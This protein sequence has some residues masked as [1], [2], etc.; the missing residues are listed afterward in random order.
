VISLMI[1]DM[2]EDRCAVYI[3]LHTVS[4]EPRIN[5]IDAAT[6]SQR[7]MI[8]HEAIFL[9]DDRRYT[10]TQS[11]QLG[12]A[13]GVCVS[14]GTRIAL[15]QHE[16]SSPS[17]ANRIARRFCK[18]QASR[19]RQLVVRPEVNMCS[20]RRLRAPWVARGYAAVA[21]ARFSLCTTFATDSII[22]QVS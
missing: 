16:R 9:T 14:A 5:L 11:T 1:W 13:G 4:R 22:R 18:R 20:D 10:G 12:S 17:S 7:A 19:V 21:H 6:R 15:R 3:A 2:P 8:V